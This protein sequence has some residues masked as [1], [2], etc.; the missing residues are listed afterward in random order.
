MTDKLSSEELVEWLD[1]MW[2]SRDIGLK[3]EETAYQEIKRRLEMYDQDQEVLFGF[4]NRL[5]IFEK[6]IKQLQKPKPV[7]RELVDKYKYS[8]SASDDPANM[9]ELI[10]EMLTELGHTIEEEK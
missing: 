4:A 1:S 10:T 8:F 7:S 9:E 5:E 3:W 2:E 6:T